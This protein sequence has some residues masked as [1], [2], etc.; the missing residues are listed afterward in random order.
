MA[1]NT[2]KTIAATTAITLA[3]VGTPAFADEVTP[4]VNASNKSIIKTD[5]STGATTEPHKVTSDEVKNNVDA[6]K[7]MLLLLNL[8]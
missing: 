6:Q 1:K 8:K 3:A 4:K 2:I 7:K 5:P